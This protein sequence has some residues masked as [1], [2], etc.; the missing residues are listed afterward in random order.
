MRAAFMKEYQQ[1]HGPVKGGNKKISELKC[2][3]AWNGMTMVEKRPY[4]DEKRLRDSEFK[5]RGGLL[6]NKKK[7]EKVQYKVK[8]RWNKCSLSKFINTVCTLGDEKR[9]DVV[10]IGFGN[11]LNLKC[12][13]LS[14]SLFDYIIGH[15][16]IK[17]RRIQLEDNQYLPINAI[18]VQKIFGLP[19]GIRDVPTCHLFKADWV[20]EGAYRSGLHVNDLMERVQQCEPSDDF[21]R[22]FVLFACATFLT[23]NGRYSVHVKE[24][25]AV[26]NVNEIKSYNWCTY[27]LETLVAHLGE[28]EGGGKMKHEYIGCLIP[29]KANVSHCPSSSW[30]GGE[31]GNGSCS[32]S[33]VECCVK[34]IRNEM[35]RE[36][37]NRKT[38]KRK[39]EKIERLV[40]KKSKGAGGKPNVCTADGG[41]SIEDKDVA[42]NSENEDEKE[43]FDALVDA[44][45]AL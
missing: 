28:S 39:V 43:T 1:V 19:A 24:L 12:D 45:E 11:L 29:F 9:K 34:E 35:E 8:S 36:V 27:V 13:H 42:Q 10:D 4:Y 44:G 17:K 2:K 25:K 6:V 33:E 5:S 32:K 22:A 3:E 15:L 16:D 41:V 14:T 37:E 30:C 7:K 26:D 40:R 38:L 18:D 31:K 20:T 21:K 23:P